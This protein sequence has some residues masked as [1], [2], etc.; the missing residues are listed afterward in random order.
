MGLRLI[1]DAKTPVKCLHGLF[2]G[3]FAFKVDTI[4]YAY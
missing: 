4:L 1:Y 2:A 3:V